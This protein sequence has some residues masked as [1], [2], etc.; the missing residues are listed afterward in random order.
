MSLDSFVVTAPGPVRWCD[1]LKGKAQ[2]EQ[3]RVL[4]N[5]QWQSLG[6]FPVQLSCNENNSVGLAMNGNNSL[7]LDFKGS[8]NSQSFSAEGTVK[9]NLETPEGLAKMMEYMGT[10]DSHGRYSFRL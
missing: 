5:N 9:P 8:I 6:D 7:G 10:P 4:V 2:G 3:I 1:E